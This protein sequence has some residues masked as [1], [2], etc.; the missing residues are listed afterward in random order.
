MSYSVNSVCFDGKEIKY[1]RF[2]KGKKQFVILPGLSIKSVIDFGAAVEK[3]YKIFNEDYS[4]YLF[5][6]AENPPENYSV[7]DMAD[8]TARAMK[9][10][11]VSN[12]CIFGASQGGMLAMLIAARYPELAEKLALGSTACITEGKEGVI[13]KW[14]SLAEQGRIKELCLSFG[15]KVYSKEVF[16]KNKSALSVVARMVTPE[17]LRRFI[18]LAK[19]TEGFNAQR[20]LKSVCCPVLIIGDSS[21]EIFGD[22]GAYDIKEALS[23]NPDTELF[24][25]NGF[26]HAVY[27]TAPDYPKRLYNFFQK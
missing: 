1:L 9:E 10:L 3:Q 26:G 27:D 11:G 19:G 5:E 21:D 25:Y 8:D 22:N 14:V 13:S 7:S 20:E 6:R 15:E 23:D 17:E 24:I 12:A 2:G 16:E 4:V 18:I